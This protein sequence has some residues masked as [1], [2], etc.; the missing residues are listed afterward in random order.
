MMPKVKKTKVTNITIFRANEGK[1]L[2]FNNFRDNNMYYYTTHKYLMIEWDI[3]NIAQFRLDGI[4]GFTT[5]GV[6]QCVD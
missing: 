5:A 3:G 6:R 2:E 4:Q 1:P